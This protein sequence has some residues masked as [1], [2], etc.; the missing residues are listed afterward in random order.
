MRDNHSLR[1]TWDVVIRFLILLELSRPIHAFI[2]FVPSP[3]MSKIRH[4]NTIKWK[5]YA[6]H[7]RNSKES[8]AFGSP[9]GKSSTSIAS[10]SLT[11]PLLEAE[12]L[13]D[14]SHVALDITTMV[15]LPTMSLRIATVIGRLLV[16]AADFLPDHAVKADELVFQVVML[17]VASHA[18]VQ[19]L[20]PAVSVSFG[21]DKAVHTRD[22]RAYKTLFAPAGVT[23]HQFKLL[24]SYAALDWITVEPGHII[25]SNEYNNGDT[26][27]DNYIYWLYQ[28]EVE[29]HRNQKLIHSVQREKNDTRSA[30]TGLIREERLMQCID[31]MKEVSS[32]ETTTGPFLATTV[33]AGSRGAKVLRIDCSR[34]RKVVKNDDELADSLRLLLLHGMRDKV[35]AHCFIDKAEQLV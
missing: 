33:K 31:E 3:A 25:S 1:C 6:A 8:L 29:V 13:N 21:Y 24:S 18:L 30:G 35:Y 4:E 19:C 23:W 16:M 17:A 28:G 9:Q 32:K 34:V 15:G 27:E 14:L 2:T 10:F 7:S 11:D 12:V 5:S 20:L 26:G 22:R